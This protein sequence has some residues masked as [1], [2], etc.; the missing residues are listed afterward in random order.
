MYLKH[1]NKV[2]GFAGLLSS[3]MTG[4]EDEQQLRTRAVQEGAGAVLGHSAK[5]IPWI[6]EAIH[7][8][9]ADSRLLTVPFM[10]VRSLQRA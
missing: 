4:A 10:P 8:I 7:D 2:H 1:H 3:A 6:G 9:P 5:Y